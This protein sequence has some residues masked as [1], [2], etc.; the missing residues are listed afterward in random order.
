MEMNKETMVKLGLVAAMVLIGASV[1]LLVKSRR[2][3]PVQMASEQ[4]IKRK[5]DQ[6]RI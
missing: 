4:V 2:K 1:T 6:M 5:Q 3:R